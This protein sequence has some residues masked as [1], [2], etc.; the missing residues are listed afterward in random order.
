M[1]TRTRTTAETS[2]T[3][4]LGVD[5]PQAADVTTGLPFLDHMLTLAA[6]HAGW[7]LTVRAEGD[8]DVDDHHTAEDVALTLGAA[9]QEAWRARADGFQRYG[10]R[11]LPMDEALVLV[12]VDLSGRPGAHVRL[13][14]R[15]D[16]VGGLAAENVDHFFASLAAAGAF[17][18]HVRRLAGRN[19]HHVVEAAFK[20]LGRALAEA[21]APSALA[22]S[23]KGSL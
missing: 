7:A 13:K 10:Q 22:P 18:L 2:V 4:E 9:L 17:T 12:A 14:L 5:G 3:V 23:T 21:L 1:I 19:A 20:G 11:A 15:R 6:F 16:A 8:L